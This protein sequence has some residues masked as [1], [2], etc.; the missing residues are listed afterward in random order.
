MKRYAMSIPLPAPFAAQQELTA[1]MQELGYT[2]LWSS[3]T[4]G[5]DAF[6]P[7]A[8]AGQVPEASEQ[9]EHWDAWFG[10]HA[11]WVP[12]WDVPELYTVATTDEATEPVASE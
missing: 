9:T 10:I 11:Q 1:R 2:D 7:L 12:F 6:T 4:A 3:E 8:L 5:Q